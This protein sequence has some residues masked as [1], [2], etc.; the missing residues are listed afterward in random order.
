[1]A[2]AWGSVQLQA[3]SEALSGSIPWARSTSRDHPQVQVQLLAVSLAVQDHTRVDVTRFVRTKP[4]PSL[5]ISPVY[6]PT[7]RAFR[8]NKGQ[9]RACFN[10]LRRAQI[11]CVAYNSLTIF[12]TLLGQTQFVS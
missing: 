12:V 3:V 7:V 4:R 8:W 10:G 1:M 9:T 5:R 2:R 11:G 6:Q